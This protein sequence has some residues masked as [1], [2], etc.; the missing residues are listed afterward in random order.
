MSE[1]NAEKKQTGQLHKKLVKFNLKKLFVE[2]KINFSTFL[3]LVSHS[4]SFYCLL[5]SPFR[6]H[7][8]HVHCLL[9]NLI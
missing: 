6:P 3:F 1:M 5:V 7:T 4:F 9:I 8:F 2:L